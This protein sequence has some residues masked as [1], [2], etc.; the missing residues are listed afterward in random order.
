MEKLISIVIPTYN[1]QNIVTYTLELLKPQVLRNIEDVEFIV[2][3]NASTDDSDALIRKYKEAN[4]FFSYIWYGEHVEVGVSISRS[5][6]NASGKYILLW[7]D[8]DFPCPF[9]IDIL[10]DVVKRNPDVGLVHFNGMKGVDASNLSLTNLS[11]FN[12]KIEQMELKMDSQTF[13]ERFYLGV[14]LMSADL[15]LLSSW[16]RGVTFD[17]SKHFG[18]EFVAPILMGIKGLNCLYLNYPLWVQRAPAYRTWQ[19][20]ATFYWF[21]GIPN[22]LRDLEQEHVISSWRKNWA[23][24][25]S[26]NMLLHM[27]PQMLLDKKFYKSHLK[28]I[29][30]NQRGTWGK[31]FICFCY[32]FIPSFIY[33]TLR[34]HHF[35][36]IKSNL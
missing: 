18:W 7:G 3:N 12:T 13:S 35:K 11:V 19:S 22:L 24:I 20:K 28:E 30:A 25:N 10:V 9:L 26:R 2:C 17:S 31:I 6:S 23:K 33:K 27:A 15:F 29:V 4:P 16:K 36:K 21:V 5:I 14:G 34:D 1:R 8:D 32:Y